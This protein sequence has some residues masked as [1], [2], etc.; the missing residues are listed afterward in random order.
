MFTVKKIPFPNPYVFRT[1]IKKV[2]FAHLLKI[3]AYLVLRF[4][5]FVETTPAIILSADGAT[6]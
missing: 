2:K 4:D 1:G 3:H 5:K 6:T